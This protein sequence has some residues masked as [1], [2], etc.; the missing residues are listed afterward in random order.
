MLNSNCVQYD[1]ASC[2]LKFFE[3]Q[4]MRHDLPYINIIMLLMLQSSNPGLP[5]IF[6]LLLH[7]LCV[8]FGQENKPSFMHHANTPV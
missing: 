6:F 7:N 5:N 4:S 2:L 3:E 1:S 8:A